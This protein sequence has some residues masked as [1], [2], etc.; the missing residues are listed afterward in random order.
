M[1]IAPGLNSNNGHQAKNRLSCSGLFSYSD[2]ET[3]K[4][5]ITLTLSKHLP[6]PIPRYISLTCLSQAPRLNGSGQKQAGGAKLTGP[7]NGD[8]FN[9]YYCRLNDVNI[10]AL[11]RRSEISCV[12]R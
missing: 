1:D 11:N 6:R 7:R 5:Q 2:Q 8:I 3:N 12:S 10:V 9:T 4:S